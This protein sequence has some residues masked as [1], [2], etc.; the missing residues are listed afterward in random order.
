MNRSHI[1]DAAEVCITQ[2]RAE[3]YGSAEAGFAAI[4]QVWSAMDLARG[5]RAFGAADVAAR[6]VAVKLIRASA[7]P[8]HLDSWI[9]ICG[10]AALGGEIA[11]EGGSS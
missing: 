8:N 2:D 5:D 6:M 11:S 3:T 7:N 4:A 9:D 1:L 10:F